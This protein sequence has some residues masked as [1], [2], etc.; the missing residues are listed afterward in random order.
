MTGNWIKAVVLG[1]AVWLAGSLGGFLRLVLGV[2]GGFV[3]RDFLFI[4]YRRN[5]I[6][7]DADRLRHRL[8]A[9]DRADQSMPSSAGSGH[10]KWRMSLSENR[11][12]LFRDMR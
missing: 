6:R 4:D 3:F 9:R 2:F 5:R 12:P 1:F 7:A 8:A 11:F 10:L